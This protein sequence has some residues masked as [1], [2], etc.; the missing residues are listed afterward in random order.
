[1]QMAPK[2]A[3]KAKA[4]AKPK[5]K[6]RAKFEAP[7]NTKTGAKGDAANG[8]DS[9][10][11]LSKSRMT[12]GVFL[13]SLL[14]EC[15]GF[16]KNV[17]SI[18]GSMRERIA[19]GKEKKNLH[20]GVFGWLRK[21]DG[22]EAEKAAEWHATYMHY[23][24]TSGLMAKIDSA[25]RLP[26]GDAPAVEGEADDE[27]ESTAGDGAGDGEGEAAEASGI[28]PATNGGTP[29]VS[30]PRFGQR[31]PAGISGTDLAAATGTDVKH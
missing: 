28:K 31:P 13:K 11:F 2:K 4:K 3:A 22:M 20:T 24:E 25:Q 5:S 26:M 12:P 15:R 30:R 19:Y 21:I 23:L 1:M 8:K 18:V 14:S 16:K 29:N 17:D 9:P 7:V 27:A 10:A 6:G